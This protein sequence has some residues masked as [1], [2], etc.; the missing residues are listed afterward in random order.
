[1]NPLPLRTI[2]VLVLVYSARKAV[3]P[4]LTYEYL[5]KKC[6]VSE[7]YV[8]MWFSG[9]RSPNERHAKILAKEL[10]CEL[11]LI[12]A[13]AATMEEAMEMAIDSTND[14]IGKSGKLSEPAPEPLG[15]HLYSLPKS[16]TRSDWIEVPLYRSV[17]ASRSG[18]SAEL[19]RD[20]TTWVP[21]DLAHCKPIV[22]SGTSMTRA[23]VDDGDIV[24]VDESARPKPGQIVVVEIHGETLLKRLV[25][26]GKT[27][28]LASE[29]DE[30]GDVKIG[31][32]GVRALGVARMAYTPKQIK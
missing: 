26:R 7:G 18:A 14:H 24:L 19:P 10:A 2:P 4:K 23:G 16:A 17:A 27:P 30:H 31:D 29:S 22:V 28:W 20:G 11:D 8:S 32:Q 9:R 12:W 15:R 21:K 25:L 6:G 5:A 1:M 3:N 13:K